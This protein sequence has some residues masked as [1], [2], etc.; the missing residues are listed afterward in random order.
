MVR[1]TK[2][3][4]ISYYSSTT[5][6]IWVEVDTVYLKLLNVFGFIY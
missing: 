1:S 4:T 6:V 2:L 5:G 3:L